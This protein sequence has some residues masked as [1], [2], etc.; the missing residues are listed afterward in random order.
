MSKNPNWT[1]DEHILAL[2]LYFT[3]DGR[4]LEPSDKKVIELSNL[5]KSLPIHSK[6]IRTEN[7]RNP[8]GVSMKLG[9]FRRLDQTLKELVYHMVRGERSLY[10]KN[11]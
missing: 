7:F 6:K 5:L 9:N 4:R 3:N 11:I 8:D 2:D 10:G 1:N